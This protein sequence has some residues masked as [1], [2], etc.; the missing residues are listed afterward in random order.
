MLG[1]GLDLAF[2]RR[3]A[4]QDVERPAAPPPATWL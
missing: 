1:A 2:I 3:H 4:K